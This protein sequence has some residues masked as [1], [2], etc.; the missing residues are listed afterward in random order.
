MPICHRQLHHVPEPPQLL[1]APWVFGWTVTVKKLLTVSC[2]R[3]CCEM[4]VLRKAESRL[5]EKCVVTCEVS[6]EKKVKIL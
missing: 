6:A 1:L 4:L 5:I 2:E 3:D